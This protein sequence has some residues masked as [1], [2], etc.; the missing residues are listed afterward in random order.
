M[1]SGDGALRLEATATFSSSGSSVCFLVFG[2]NLSFMTVSAVQR[3]VEKFRVDDGDGG[4]LRE[5]GG[6]GSVKKVKRRMKE[7]AS[8]A[9]A[10]DHS[11]SLT[12]DG[13]CDEPVC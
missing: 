12:S 6:S 4:C 10:L 2:F 9:F 7:K 5:D 13:S 11:L 1:E 8:Y 3:S